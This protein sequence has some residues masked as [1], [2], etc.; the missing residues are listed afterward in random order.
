MQQREKILAG[1][2]LGV[3]VI[4]QV[5]STLHA[6]FVAPLEDRQSKID[7]LKGSIKASGDREFDLIQA[8]AKLATA[9]KHCFPP[10]PLTAQRMY[11]SWLTDLAAD[12]GFSN[13]KII[14][15]KR[16]PKG[17]TYQAI[18][19]R[20][21][22]RATIE[23]LAEFL[24]LFCESGLLHRINNLVVTSPSHTGNP[25]LEVEFV[26]QG[27]SFPNASPRDFLLPRVTI[28]KPL[29][30]LTTTLKLDEATTSSW[31]APLTIRIGR[32]I[33]N[34][35]E[36]RDN[37]WI[38]SRGAAGTLSQSH[39]SGANAEILLSD[40]GAKE[41]K[42]GGEASL[43]DYQTLIATGPFS[44]PAPPK[45]Y[46]PN[47]KN[48]AD[49]KTSPGATVALQ[50]KVDDWNPAFGEPSYQLIK[51][52]INGVEFDAQ[53]GSLK[54]T[55]PEEMVDGTFDFEIRVKDD[56]QTFED[57]EKF[58]I[59][60]A[61][62]NTPPMIAEVQPD[63]AFPGQTW[64][65]QLDARDSDEGQKL[66]YSLSG[67]NPEGVVIDPASGMVI[68]DVPE[69]LQPSEMKLS[70]TVADDGNPPLE[71]KTEIAVKVM[72]DVAAY[73]Y[74][75]ACIDRENDQFAW[76][77]NRLDETRLT[78]RVGDDIETGSVKGTVSRIFYNGIEL[79]SAGQLY[80]LE[81]GR[82]LRQLQLL[83]AAEK[84]EQTPSNVATPVASEPE[85]P[86]MPEDY[87]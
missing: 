77:F 65:F 34:V 48:I 51:P 85:A 39:A 63:S 13:P 7:M 72:D 32:E 42:D 57:T 61:T 60:V 55:V 43:A 6:T 71:T 45:T 84:S 50:A 47:L 25:L 33:M 20:V 80:R 62:P 59:A 41:A 5:R 58:Q 79:E 46:R 49:I 66:V 15:Q 38:V 64:M 16:T 68:W 52:A 26:A 8:T 81:T 44:I 28:E 29:D 56:N 21:E 31:K 30:D 53:S 54:W 69:S 27:L 87:K 82:H 18:D 24:F 83:G 10:D 86:A 9:K 12:V 3:V 70:F 19:V 35:T 74:L 14:P 37:T 17:N 11:Q 75:V 73:T 40:A 1:L 67:E 36:A 76:I 4:W 22:T 78:V 2:L 23:Q